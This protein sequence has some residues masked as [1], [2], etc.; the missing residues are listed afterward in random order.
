[1]LTRGLFGL[2][3]GVAQAKAR[4]VGVSEGSRLGGLRTLSS[5]DR[6]ADYKKEISDILHDYDE[7]KER[8]Q[9]LVGTIVS[10]KN[11][12]TV[13]VQVLR[14]KFFPKYNKVLS[15]RKKVM[16]HDEE[17]IGSVGDVVRIVPCR[18][19]SRMKRHKLLDI[20]RKTKV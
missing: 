17:E 19:M 7:R 3:R 12:K 13:S 20:L 15:A 16:A 2:R 9:S 11:Q 18:P 10:T 5:L 1:M 6:E 4:L 14:E 8:R